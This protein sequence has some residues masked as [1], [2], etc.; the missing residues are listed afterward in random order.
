MASK[1]QVGWRL[2]EQLLLRLTAYSEQ[3]HRSVNSAAVVLLERIL[4][5]AEEQGEYEYNPDST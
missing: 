3:H 1:R 4:Q 5:E 2:P